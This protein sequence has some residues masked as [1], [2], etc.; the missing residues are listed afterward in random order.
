MIAAGI[1]RR[2]KDSPLL[3]SE[4]G[5]AST[6]VR[7]SGLFARSKN[8]NS[9]EKIDGKIP[10]SSAFPNPFLALSNFAKHLSDW[11]PK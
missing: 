5:A 7:P 9:F 11:D 6:G 1:E 4:M 2:A 3:L 10:L 8:G